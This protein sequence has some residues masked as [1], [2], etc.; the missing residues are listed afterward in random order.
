MTKLCP[1]ATPPIA[2]VAA[3]AVS[4]FQLRLQKRKLAF[5]VV[6]HPFSA[7]HSLTFFILSSSLP[8]THDTKTR[9][10]SQAFRPGNFRLATGNSR[11]QLTEMKLPVSLLPPSVA[12]L[13]LQCPSLN[14]LTFALRRRQRLQ[15]QLKSTQTERTLNYKCSH[16]NNSSHAHCRCSQ[17]RPLLGRMC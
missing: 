3:I 5:I 10:F 8:L 16:C 11:C 13:S 1:L 15:L 2:H 6:T 17:P 7:S 12:H 9:L 4:V 14:R